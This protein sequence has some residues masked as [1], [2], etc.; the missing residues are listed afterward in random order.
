MAT[1]VYTVEEIELQDGTT[2]GFKP[3][4]LKLLR[5]FMKEF[6]SLEPVE[7]EDESIDQFVSLV[8]ICIESV[9]KELAADR[10]KLEEVLDNPTIFKIIEVCT[11]IK[12]NDPNLVAAAMAAM[13]AGQ[14]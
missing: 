2:Y 11:G 6:T 1:T 3:L 9:D 8:S 4:N 12:L 13:E 14:N 5:R 10:D 7:T